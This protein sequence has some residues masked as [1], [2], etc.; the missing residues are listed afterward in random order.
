MEKLYTY[1]IYLERSEKV[2]GTKISV[3]SGQ[4]GFKIL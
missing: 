1:S 4:M 2:V 3:E